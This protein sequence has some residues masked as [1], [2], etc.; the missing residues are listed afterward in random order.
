M[1]T[2]DTPY[3]TLLNDHLVRSVR[4]ALEEDLGSG[5][6]TA[7][8]IP[9]DT[10]AR[11]HVI[12]RESGVLCGRE[13]FDECFR[14]ID[15][16]VSLHWHRED[17]ADLAPNDT[18]VEIH[19]RARSILTAERAALNFLQTLSG[20]ASQARR[21]AR[22]TEGTGVTIL[23][24]RKTLP[25]LRLAQ[26]Y[27]TRVGGCDNHRLGLYDLFLIKENHITACGGIRPAI[28]QARALKADI[29]VEIEVE[30][31]AQLEEAI[32]AGADIVMLD[33]FDSD[34][35]RQAVEIARRRVKLE[36]SGNLD[37]ERLAQDV[38]AGPGVDYASVGAI[39]KHV[40]ALDL[41]LRL[42]MLDAAP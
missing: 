37:L 1:F 41:S 17:G 10:R 27:A 9:A 6:I 16:E 5:D 8:L 42:Q 25:G 4:F 31:L 26:K 2:T 29:P 33:N 38:G 13:W 30:T 23:D 34:A 40:Q 3:A 18:L 22:L 24:T 39:T 35:T 7:A 19:G 28:A 21:Y 32:A 14:Q 11:A 20:T 15:P 36:S 12:T